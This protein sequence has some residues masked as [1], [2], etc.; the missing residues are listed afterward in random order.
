MMR[1]N[2]G[3]QARPASRRT[4]DFKAGRNERGSRGG[5]RNDKP[6]FS[7]RGEKPRFGNKDDRKPAFGRGDKPRFSDS[8]PRFQDRNND[9]PRFSDRDD[10]LRFADRNDKPR[11]GDRDNSFKPRREFN[12]PFDK[13]SERKQDSRPFFE[14][15]KRSTR[16]DEWN[17][18]EQG[19]RMPFKKPVR[20]SDDYDPDAKY[21]RK[22][23]I[24]HRKKL[25][26]EMAEVRLN[27]YLANAGIC[28]RREADELIAAGVVKVNGA[29]VTEL[30]TR[31]KRSD[32]VHFH[33]QLVRSEQ[34]VYILLNKP[35]NCVTTSD[36]PQERMTV[37]DLVK[38]ACSERIYP[39]GR[40]DRNTTGVL[41][42]TNDGDMAAELT[43]PKNR[44][45][46]VYHVHLDK[47]FTKADMQQLADGIT[48]EDGD[49]K[50]DQISYVDEED[51]KQVG[52][53]VHSGR[54]RLVRRMFEY[55]G[56]KVEKLDRVYFA[57]LT[58]KGLNRGKWRFLTAKEL[59]M[60]Q[61]KA[62][63]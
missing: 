25:L 12:K 13:F 19:E 24:E 57:G 28:S 5:D 29:V 52:I 58:K 49:I 55:L 61:M 7:D 35:K 53:E 44:K 38:D 37:M 46:K 63:E 14:R 16:H 59:Q 17:N 3:R 18:D 51:K 39:V 15:E 41:L 47:P 20:R 26:A 9:R 56:Y 8:K 10:K 21:S 45:K 54:N 11:F 62:Y 42:L 48:L 36:D 23:Q 27:R 60:L 4:D 31:V 22:K 43:H 34:K 1:N 2:N 30:G 6:R 50:A 33:D 32:T 40:L